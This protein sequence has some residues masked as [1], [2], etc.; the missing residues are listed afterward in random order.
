[1]A[2]LAQLARA[3]QVLEAV[4]EIAE[5]AERALVHRQ[6]ERLAERAALE[7]LA[8]AVGDRVCGGHPDPAGRARPLVVID[9]QSALVATAVRVS[10]HVLVD[11]SVL[12]EEIVEPELARLR[13]QRSAVEQ[14][15][16]L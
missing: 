12:T 5:A 6:T 13:E 7:P 11:V 2:L 16:D 4:G 10:E 8:A 15:K 3:P 9:D 14:R 1:E